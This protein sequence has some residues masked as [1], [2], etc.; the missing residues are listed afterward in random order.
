MPTQAQWRAFLSENLPAYMIPSTIH[1]V[2]TIPLNAAGKVDRLALLA[3][4]D[5]DAV[6]LLSPA[7]DQLRTPPQNAIE[8]RIA[9]IWAQQLGCPQIVR[10]DNFF[11][12][13]GNSLKAIAAIGRLRREFEC[14]VNDLYE[15]PGL[16]DFA[17]ICRPRP[18]H[19]RTIVE[20]VC[21][22]WEG[23]RGINTGREGEREDALRAQ[24]AVYEARISATLAR[25]LEARQPYRHVAADRSNR[26]SGQLPFARTP[27]VPQDAG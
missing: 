2:A 4:M 13:G 5:A 23:G 10:E 15:H 11:E 3:G 9:E 24:R 12:L 7:E 25:D 20:E 6:S 22:A 19:L 17:R 1:R 21:A 16:T 27:R 8:K 14:R 26:L 18:D